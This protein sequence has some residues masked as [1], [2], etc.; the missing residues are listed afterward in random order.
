MQQTTHLPCPLEL[1]CC[2]FRRK[3]VDDHLH[4]PWPASYSF[5]RPLDQFSIMLPE[6]SNDE[7]PLKLLLQV[8]T[9][10]AEADEVCCQCMF[11]MR[12][13]RISPRRDIKLDSYA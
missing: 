4:H 8:N 2:L 1:Q 9:L 13:D 7:M 10:Y 5:T 6:I 11:L 3:A 12:K